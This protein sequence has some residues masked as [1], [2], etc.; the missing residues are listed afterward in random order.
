MYFNN[1]E[2]K[3][4][5]SVSST[6]ISCSILELAI[7]GIT[8]A[9]LAR[10]LFIGSHDKMPARGV[11]ELHLKSLV[12]NGLL[13]ELADKDRKYVAYKTTRQGIQHLLVM[14]N[15]ATKALHGGSS[16]S[17]SSSP[18]PYTLDAMVRLSSII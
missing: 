15:N 2:Q 3:Q 17:L 11:I 4:P 18:S 13:S 1:E 7:Y 16:T 6:D 9:Y 10:S 12:K 8:E 14:N 5:S